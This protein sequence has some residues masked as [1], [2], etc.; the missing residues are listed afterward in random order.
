MLGAEAEQRAGRQR[1]VAHLQQVHGRLPDERRDERVDRVLVD[2]LRRPD[3]THLA[4]VHDRDPVAQP[5]RLHL[6]VR[7][8]HGGPLD[9]AL[10]P[11]Q[12]VAGRVPQL[13]VEVRE[14]LVE[15]EHLR[16]P[17]QGATQGHALPFAAG[18]LARIALE[19]AGDAEHLGRPPHLVRDLRTGHPARLERKS[20][21]L[22]D[23]AVRIEGVALEDHCDAARPWRHVRI[24]ALAANEDLARGRPLQPRNHPEQGRLAAPRRTEQH[25]ELPLADGQIDSVHRVEVT[26]SSA[27]VAQLDADHDRV[28]TSHFHR[29][30]RG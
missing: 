29:H 21:V 14:R 15:E 13:G 17:D 19:V 23:G 11:L 26:E 16:V 1:R 30:H 25:E 4:V 9:P 18:E 12:L 24:D 5:H 20:D 6:V 2:L 3:L 8:V 28:S 7:H 27:Q 10:K 22:C